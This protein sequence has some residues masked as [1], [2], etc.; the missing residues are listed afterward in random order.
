MRSEF[1]LG[2]L[3]PARRAKTA[4]ACAARPCLLLAE[5]VGPETVAREAAPQKA[6]FDKAPDA[7]DEKS[8]TDRECQERED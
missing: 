1:D 2:L 5:R 7:E 6:Q 3:V 8:K 4:P